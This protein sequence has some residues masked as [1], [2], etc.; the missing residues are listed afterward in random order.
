MNDKIISKQDEDKISKRKIKFILTFIDMYK[1]FLEKI[2]L[3]T[4]NEFF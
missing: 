4:K 3:L 1:L 2:S